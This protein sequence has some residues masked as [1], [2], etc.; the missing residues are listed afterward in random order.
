MSVIKG[1][2]LITVA[3]IW[4]QVMKRADNPG[5]LHPQSDLMEVMMNTGA[6][7]EGQTSRS[8]RVT[9]LD[10]ALSSFHNTDERITRRFAY[11]SC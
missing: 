10:Y 5:A 6:I 9:G 4:A 8:G 2:L 11:P 7:G 1:G 3:Y